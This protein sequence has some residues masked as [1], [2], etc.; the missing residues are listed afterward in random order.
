[1]KFSLKSKLL[2]LLV[3]ASIIALGKPYVLPSYTEIVDNAMKGVL[4]IETGTDKPGP[5]GTTQI[6]VGSGFFID[7]TGLIVTNAHVIADLGSPDRLHVRSKFSSKW[8]DATV[9]AGDE[10][11]DVAELRIDDWQT[12]KKEVP[13]TALHFA[14][15]VYMKPGQDV[16]AIGM[17]VGMTWSVTRG[18]LSA[19]WR[20]PE[21]ESPMFYLQD[22]LAITHGNSGGPLFDMSGNVVGINNMI[23]GLEEGGSI[24]FAIP[25]E[26]VKK[27][28][29]DFAAGAD[30]ITWATLGV[31]YEPSDDGVGMY[32]KEIIP[33]SAAEG[34]IFPGDT[35]VSVSTKYSGSPPY[36]LIEQ[37]DLQNHVFMLDP[38]EHVILQ[39][40]DKHDKLRTVNIAV[41]T[42]KTSAQ[43]LAA[44]AAQHK[45]EEK[46]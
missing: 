30:N 3:G 24:A 2:G 10:L 1:M 35:I 16:W 37:H 36:Q 18:Y 31:A 27:V 43:I 45:H 32:V 41:G 14:P 12:F 34:S 15:T 42:G 29:R 20:K 13:W 38:G 17:P 19:S 40:V 6:E 33:K 39:V 21:P 44:V 26:M 25:S 11:S 4:F 22:D 7:N 28:I 9:V 5:Q 8:Y 23:R 46:Q